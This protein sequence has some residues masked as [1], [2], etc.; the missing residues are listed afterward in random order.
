MSGPNI[1]YVMTHY[2]RVALS[3]ITGEVDEME[4]L[5]ATIHP[6]AMNSPDDADLLSDDAR[7]RSAKTQYLKSGRARLLGAFLSATARHPIGTARLVGTALSSARG[8]VPLMARRMSHLLQA[9][10]VAKTCRERNIGH[11]HAHFGQAPATI[12]WFAAELMKLDG[13]ATWSFTIHGFQDFVDETIARLDLKAES[14]AF[15]VCISDFTRSQLCRLLHPSLWG[16]AKVVRCGIDLGLF[17][18]RQDRPLASPAKIISVGRLSSE[19]GQVVLLNA[20]KLLVDRGMPLHLTFIG[21]GPLE[22]L[23]REQIAAAGL[24]THVELRG[25]LPADA[26]RRELEQSDLFCLTSFAEGLPVSIM[27]AMAIGVPV[28]ATTI[29]GIPELAVNRETALTVA[30]CNA[31][32]LAD[33][34]AE[35]L[36][37]SN[38]RGRIV[39]AARQKVEEAHDRTRNTRQLYDL[40]A[41]VAA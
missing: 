29:A 6:F 24:G 16:K 40:F 9:A 13:P 37:D 22:Q 36:G 23:L 10:G 33:A 39:P 14:A 34:I 7:A 30:P 31:E 4:R 2:P 18:M 8:D 12:A 19:K 27:E 38:L 17:A 26:V 32:Q 5:G 25:E 20:C 15:V 41:G 11:L 28:I 35:L 21:S 1:A 3:F